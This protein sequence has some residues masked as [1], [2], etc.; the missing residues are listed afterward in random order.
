MITINRGRY[1]NFLGVS[2]TTV[3]YRDQ[4]L[5][6]ITGENGNG[7]SSIFIEGPYFGLFGSSIRYGDKP[8][9]LIIKEGQNAFAV[10]HEVE[11]DG[12]TYVIARCK[13]FKALVKKGLTGD[14][15]LPD[16]EYPDGLSVW[17]NNQN[18]ARGHTSDTQEWLESL[19]A[20]GPRTSTLR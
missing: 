3:P 11:I 4:G 19:Y 2:D 1:I 14:F 18:E 16:R 15:V 10:L 8:S 17:H 13:R 9:D 6:L 7:K 12:E 20:M 5:V